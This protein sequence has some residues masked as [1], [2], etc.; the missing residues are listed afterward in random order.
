MAILTFC[1]KHKNGFILEMVRN[2]QFW[3]NFWFE[4]MCKVIYPVS[5]KLCAIFGGL[6][7]M[8]LFGN[9]ARFGLMFWPERYVQRHLPILPKNCSPTI[10][11]SHF[12]LCPPQY[13]LFLLFPA[14]A[15]CRHTWFPVI[16]RKNV[17]PIFTKFGMGV[18]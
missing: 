2:E 14:S 18:Y 3:P 17:Y 9:D 15:V 8:H 16:S 5:K 12:E 7:E 10:F 4:C 1:V 11:G 6:R 13:L